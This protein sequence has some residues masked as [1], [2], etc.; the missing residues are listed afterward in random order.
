[1]YGC[2][3]SITI[4][5]NSLAGLEFDLYLGFRISDRRYNQSEDS[6]NFTK[7]RAWNECNPDPISDRNII[8]RKAHDWIPK[9]EGIRDIPA[10]NV[11]DINSFVV[12]DIGK[13]TTRSSINLSKLS[14]CWLISECNG[15]G[16]SREAVQR[17]HKVCTR[18][19]QGDGS[20]GLSQCNEAS[21]STIDRFKLSQRMG[22]GNE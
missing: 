1:M 15:T 12:S 8:C 11:D 17:S 2:D 3:N 6:P 21:S 9:S 13:T 20:I 18:A 7:L 16:I 10:R 4:C 22:I 19:S 5:I 14:E